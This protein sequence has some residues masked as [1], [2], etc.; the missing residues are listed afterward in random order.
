MR[1][2][3]IWQS[4]TGPRLVDKDTKTTIEDWNDLVVDTIIPAL[5][6][7]GSLWISGRIPE[8]VIIEFA[9]LFPSVVGDDNLPR[10]FKMPRALDPLH[11]GD[12][13]DDE[14]NP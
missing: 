5:P 4:S 7:E 10:D 13:R 12:M 8:T 11:P 6:C 1:T 3:I 9:P 2:I 14:G